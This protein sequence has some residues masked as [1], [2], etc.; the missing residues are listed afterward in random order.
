MP[1]IT[2]ISFSCLPLIP[3]RSACSRGSWGC[4]WRGS[5]LRFWYPAWWLRCASSSA[6]HKTGWSSA[7]CANPAAQGTPCARTRFSSIF[8]TN[9]QPMWSCDWCWFGTAHTC[10]SRAES[11]PEPLFWAAHISCLCHHEPLSTMLLRCTIFRRLTA[12]TAFSFD[13]GL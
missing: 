5:W 1:S 9:S 2:P 13:C 8:S 11:S 4:S 3:K 7:S 6:L 10:S 12:T